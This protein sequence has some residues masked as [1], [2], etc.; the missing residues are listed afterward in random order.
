M[1]N[2]AE[3]RE[4]SQL[5]SSIKTD[6]SVLKHQDPERYYNILKQL[7]WKE[8]TPSNLKRSEGGVSKA[9][10][11]DIRTVIWPRIIKDVASLQRIDRDGDRG[12]L[13]AL[14]KDLGLDLA[15]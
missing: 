9:I 12:F 4:I 8:I 2:T 3:A 1:E 6:V 10:D 14:R 13:K 11:R 5:K 15:I 7:G